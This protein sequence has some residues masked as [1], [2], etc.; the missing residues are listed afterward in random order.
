MALVDCLHCV[1]LCSWCI[2]DLPSSPAHNPRRYTPTH[3]PVGS[4]ASTPPSVSP[5]PEMTAPEIQGPTKT[6]EMMLLVGGMDTEGEIFDD[7]LVFLLKDHGEDVD[8]DVEEPVVN[9]AASA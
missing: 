9:G 1:D 2:S 3:S 6:V 7:C 4:A 5:L 8:D